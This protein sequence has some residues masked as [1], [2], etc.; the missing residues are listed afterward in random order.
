MSSPIVTLTTDWGDSSFFAGMV[1]GRL[2]SAIPDVR[3]VDISHSLKPYDL[4]GAA[5]VIQN[6]CMGF[7]AGTVHIIDILS[8]EQE[9]QGF[10][11]VQYN[12]QYYLC[13][14]NGLPYILFGDSYQQVVELNAFWAS[15][16]YTFA[17]YEIF[18]QSA[19]SLL[20][21]MSLSDLG[22]EVALV[23]RR[24]LRFMVSEGV[25]KTHVWHVDTY[26]NAYL[27]IRYD[28]LMEILQ[29]QSFDI[30]IRG[31]H[32]NDIK[33]AY[34]ECTQSSLT[35]SESGYME[36]ALYKN[37]AADMLGLKVGDIVDIKIR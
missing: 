15:K 30:N 25:V 32:I 18:C 11:A 8:E 4:V 7:P 34:A 20:S 10:I 14:N 24:L 2:C 28:E 16:F 26:G 23:E 9:G 19:S 3:V 12:S 31:V 13:T 29:K 17:A 21:G 35:V 6:A 22:R 37:R 1:K 5:F 33:V 36:V 27:D